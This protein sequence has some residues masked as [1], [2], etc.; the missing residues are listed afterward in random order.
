MP[1]PLLAAAAAATIPSL[2]QLATGSGQVKKGKLKK[3]A[4][5]DPIYKTPG[6][7]KDGLTLA[8]QQYFNSSLPGR[9][10]AIEDI[11]AGTANGMKL[12]TEAASSSGDILD[13]VSKLN[14]NEGQNIGNL[15][16]K[17]AQYKAQQ[18]ANLQNQLGIAAEYSDKEFAYNQDRPYQQ[19][20]ADA[21]AMIAAGNTNVGNGINGASSV[22]TSAVMSGIGGAKTASTTPVPSPTNTNSILPGSKQVLINP[23][24]GSTMVFDPYTRKMVKK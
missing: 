13:G 4:I 18:L 14:F 24:L 20:M 9:S 1:I 12:I 17:E 11:K 21:N 6:A 16:D 2:V 19:E 10:S 15:V 8:E 3:A 7:I 22:L 5:V 23:G